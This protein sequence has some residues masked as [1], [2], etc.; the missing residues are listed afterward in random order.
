M[1]DL[2]KQKGT[3]TS[4]P[5][6]TKGYLGGRWRLRVGVAVH[7]AVSQAQPFQLALWDGASVTP[8]AT[9]YSAFEK[10]GEFWVGRGTLEFSGVR[11]GFETLIDRD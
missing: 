8:L 7:S 9:G 5:T 4:F 10:L 3:G 6:I 1:Q 11:F 2:I